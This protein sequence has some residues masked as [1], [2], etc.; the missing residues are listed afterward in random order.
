MVTSTSVANPVY[1]N[2]ITGNT[3]N[4]KVDAMGKISDF[5]NKVSFY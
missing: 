4:W 1:K 2:V 5:L 3:C